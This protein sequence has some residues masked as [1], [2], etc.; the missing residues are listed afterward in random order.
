MPDAAT[1]HRIC[2]LEEIPDRDGVLADVGGREIGVFRVD[3]ELYAYA[4]RCLHQGGPV[5]CG[6]LIGAT[7]T[8]LGPGGVFE[9][10]VLDTGEMRL[11]CPW[12]GWE[13]DLCSGE[14]VHDRRRRLRS[15][16]VT[17]EDGVVYVDA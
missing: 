8:E 7:R 5:C 4:N 13:Y 1:R 3:D 14:L 9:R 10:Q 11:T 2:R 16:P 6:E 17:V 12:H 15:F